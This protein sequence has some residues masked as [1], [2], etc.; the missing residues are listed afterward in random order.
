MRPLFFFLCLF[1]L[2]V[3]AEVLWGSSTYHC[4]ALRSSTND[5]WVSTNL[6]IIGLNKEAEGLVKAEGLDLSYEIYESLDPL[7][8]WYKSSAH[9]DLIYNNI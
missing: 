9:K 2:F 6:K 7:Y 1:D 5:M 3:F 8:I 4:Q